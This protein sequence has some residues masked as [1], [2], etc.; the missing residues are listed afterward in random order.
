MEQQRQDFEAATASL[1]RAVEHRHSPVFLK[2]RY[3]TATELGKLPAELEQRYQSRLA[4]AERAARIRWW[5]GCTGLTAGVVLIVVM[6]VML[7]SRQLYENRVAAATTDLRALIDAGQLDKAD[8]LVRN[9]S[10]Q[11]KQDPR[12]QELIALLQKRHKRETG[13]ETQFSE[14]LTAAKQSMDELVKQLDPE[15]GQTVLGRLGTELDHAQEQLEDARKLAATDDDRAAVAAA[16]EFASEV[17]DK[18]QHQLDRA[19][20]KQYE[21]FDRQLTKVGR[22]NHSDA[23]TLAPRSTIA[24]ND[25]KSG[26]TPAAASARRC[27]NESQRSRNG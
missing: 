13:R 4:A 27:C 18:W 24:A 11:V 2:E 6:I 3:R 8:A 5:L 19:F 17:N 12:V 9:L 20:L 26:R 22:D 14:R 16:K 10:A 1:A 23:K 15:P 7:V 25:C 21:D